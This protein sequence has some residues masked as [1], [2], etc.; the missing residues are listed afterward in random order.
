MDIGCYQ[1]LCGKNDPLFLFLFYIGPARAWHFQKPTGPGFLS[2]R[3]VGWAGPMGL[4]L[5]YRLADGQS[6]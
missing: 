1:L 6:S 2:K 4:A 5:H 3:P